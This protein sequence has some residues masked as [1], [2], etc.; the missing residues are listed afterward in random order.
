MTPAQCR[1]ARELLGLTEDHL[2]DMADLRR[3][4]GRGL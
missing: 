3:F 4:D 1:K 2:V